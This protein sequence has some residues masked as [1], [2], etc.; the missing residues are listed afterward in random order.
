M[1]AIRLP[2][3][4]RGYTRIRKVSANHAA[5]ARCIK[6]TESRERAGGKFRLLRG[7]G[8]ATPSAAASC[9]D[10]YS[11]IRGKFAC[12]VLAGVFFFHSNA[13]WEL[14]CRVPCGEG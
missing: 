10:V 4:A 2:R 11:F 14:F 1:R 8:G 7:R 6:M 9:Q 13:G 5:A 3:L 12:V